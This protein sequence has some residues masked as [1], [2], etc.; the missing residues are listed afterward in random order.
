MIQRQSNNQWNGG[1]AAH[2][3]PKIPS[4][5]I[6]WE[7][8]RLDFLGSRRHPPHW[9]SLN[10][11]TFWW[12]NAAGR[13]PRGSCSCTTMTRFAGQLQPG[14]KWPIWASS[15]LITHPILR[16]W[17]HRTTTSSLD[18]KNPFKGCHFSSDAEVISAAET[19]L[20]GKPE[21]FFE[22]LAKVRA[23]G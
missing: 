22:C 6:R 12:K 11:R 16:I 9:L 14:R 13:S 1:I 15:V 20:D 10:W 18:W 4:A 5:K 2:P 7:S 23:T 3:A 17:L 19:W 21:F 8:S